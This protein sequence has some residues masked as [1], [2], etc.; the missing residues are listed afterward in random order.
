MFCFVSMALL[1]SLLT[2]YVYITAQSHADYVKVRTSVCDRPEEEL[3]QLVK[4]AHQVHSILNSLGIEHW[5]MYGSIFGA[6]R[7]QKPLPWDYDVDI[8]VKGEQFSKIK[9]SV[10]VE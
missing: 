9:F 8:G 5:L 4:L 10:I 2:T 1:G 7:V 6:R 3:E